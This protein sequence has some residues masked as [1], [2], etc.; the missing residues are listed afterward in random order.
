MY[1][2]GC[3]VF[4]IYPEK[5]RC[6]KLV[7][8]LR[9]EEYETFGMAYPDRDCAAGSRDSIVILGANHCIRRSIFS[10]LRFRGSVSIY[11]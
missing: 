1:C 7:N 11:R 9:A 4:V 3:K 6:G 5:T 2:K 8:Q 10:A